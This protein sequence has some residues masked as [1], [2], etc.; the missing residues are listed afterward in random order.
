MGYGILLDR[1]DADDGVPRLEL[2]DG[3]AV[4][5]AAVA[6][7]EL[8]GSDP[9]L[10]QVAVV[11]GSAVVGGTSRAHVLMSGEQ[12]RAV[13]DGDGATLPGY[14][15]QYEL[16]SFVCG[17]CGRVTYR[18]HLDPRE[19]PVCAGGHGPLERVR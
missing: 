3:V 9:A 19:V 5:D 8:F 4:L 14:S 13:G 11:V 18:L 6:L 1:D 12:E 7:E 15:S 17:V 2:P 16:L 10:E